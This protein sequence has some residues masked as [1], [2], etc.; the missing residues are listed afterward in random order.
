MRGRIVSDEG[1]WPQHLPASLEVPSYKAENSG[2]LESGRLDDLRG[3][4]GPYS[5][6]VGRRGLRAFLAGGAMGTG[7][8][9]TWVISMLGVS[10]NRSAAS[11]WTD[12]AGSDA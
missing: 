8:V 1:C 12:T 9:E 4:W 10:S 7:V 3:L 6:P 2:F 5:S 11:S